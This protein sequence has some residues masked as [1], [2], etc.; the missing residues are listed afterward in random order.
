VP[1]AGWPEEFPGQPNAEI[2]VNEVPVEKRFADVVDRMWRI[3]GEQ[4]SRAYLKRM[5]EDAV[6][7]EA[8]DEARVSSKPC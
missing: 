3:T 4:T 6:G 2:A 7:E 8:G 1:V 5:G